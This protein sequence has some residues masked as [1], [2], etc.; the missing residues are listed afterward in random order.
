M[1]SIPS[2]WPPFTA[3]AQVVLASAILAVLPHDASAQS[4]CD[5]GRVQRIVVES[6]DVFDVSQATRESPAPSVH[7]FGNAIHMRT[8]ESYIRGYL[9]FEQGECF[10]AFLTA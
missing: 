10:Y 7:R 3:I 4:D 6:V 2:N 8:R 5:D 1:T 9:L